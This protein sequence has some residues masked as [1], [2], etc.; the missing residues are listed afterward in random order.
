MLFKDLWRKRNIIDFVFFNPSSTFLFAPFLV[1]W[2]GG[3]SPKSFCFFNLFRVL[4]IFFWFFK[5]L[6]AF[7]FF[8][9]FWISTFFDFFNSNLWS[10]YSFFLGGRVFKL[11]L[12][13]FGIFRNVWSIFG[14]FFSS[15]FL[16]LFSLVFV[17]ILNLFLWNL[18]F[19]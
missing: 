8:H 2:G 13:F 3:V 12:V 17:D 7:S 9:S 11:L 4:P 18:F 14:P 1:S 10:S 6:L 19:V 5:I 16:F 15:S